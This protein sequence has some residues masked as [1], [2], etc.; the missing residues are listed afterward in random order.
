MKTILF[1]FDG[2]LADTSPGIIT[3]YQNAFAA[4]N[5]PI[6][7]TEFIRKTIGP[8]LKDMLRIMSPKSNEGEIDALA[9]EYRKYFSE[10]GL[11]RMD[12]YEGILD[13]LEYLSKKATLGI[14][15]SKPEPYIIRIL[16]KYSLTD[17][18][19]LITGVSL[20]FNNKSKKE[21]LLDLV[22]SNNLT[23]SDCIM[24][25]DR[26]EDCNAASF[27]EISFI[28]AGYGFGSAD[29]FPDGTPVASDVNRLSELLEEF[30]LHP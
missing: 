16:E 28:G 21:R 9:T 15:S 1:D 27:A 12:F 10:E 14:V 25:G 30:L 22:D 19:K 2:T 17:K 7:D 3:S 5:L 24:I 6:P 18:F 26:M 20:G 23:H 8:P 29:E 13:F 4:L 11:F